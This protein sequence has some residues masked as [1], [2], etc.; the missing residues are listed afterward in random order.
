MRAGEGEIKLGRDSALE[1]VKMFG[2]RQHRLHHV[3]IVDPAG[4]HGSQC[5]CQEVGLLLVVA[6][7]ADAVAGFQHRFQQGARVAGLHLLAAGEVV[8]PR[9]ARLAVPG[10]AVPVTHVVRFLLHGIRISR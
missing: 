6:L 9:K 7:Q 10:L 3:Q 8:G 4:V 1:H 5:G 2:Q